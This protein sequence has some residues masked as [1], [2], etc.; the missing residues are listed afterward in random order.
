MHSAMTA[1][2]DALPGPCHGRA[3]EAVIPPDLFTPVFAISR[4]PSWTNRVMEQLDNRLIRPDSE[5]IGER[6]QKWVPIDER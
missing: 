2:M 6:D 5:Y 1:A 3:N 4:M